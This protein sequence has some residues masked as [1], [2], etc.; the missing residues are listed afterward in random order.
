VYLP[1][2]KDTD[3]KSGNGVYIQNNNVSVVE[4]VA[5][6]NGEAELIIPRF[7]NF[8]YTDLVVGFAYL[9]T[10][11]SQQVTALISNSDCCTSTPTMAVVKSYKNVHFLAKCNGGLVTTFKLP[12]HVSFLKSKF[13]L[14]YPL[15]RILTLLDMPYV[16][17]CV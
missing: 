15:Y 2:D 13:V 11:P 12:L 9:E 4:G 17:T 6:F 7:A 14:V 1:F 16:H 5:Y 3:D 10:P 8:E